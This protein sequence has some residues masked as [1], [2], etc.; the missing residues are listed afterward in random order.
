MFYIHALSITKNF[1]IVEG[2]YVLYCMISELHDIERNFMQQGFVRCLQRNF[3]SNRQSVMA[4]YKELCICIQVVF[5]KV[6]D[7]Y[8]NG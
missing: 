1:R 8:Y 4:S 7:H 2:N 3:V 6:V 5:M